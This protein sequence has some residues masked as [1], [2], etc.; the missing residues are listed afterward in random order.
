MRIHWQQL[1]FVLMTTACCSCSSGRD[2]GNASPTLDGPAALSTAD[3]KQTGAIEILPGG[4][5]ES[6]D[7]G[8]LSIDWTEQDGQPLATI[9]TTEAM[10]LRAAYLRI[11]IPGTATGS[12]SVSPGPWAGEDALSIA[13]PSADNTVDIGVCML[14]PDI[15]AG[16]SGSTTLATISFN[17]EAEVASTRT[18]S[19]PPVS[20][21][22]RIDL[23]YDPNRNFFYWYYRNQ[24]DYDQNG[25]VNVSDLTPIAVHFGKTSTGGFPVASVESVVDG[26]GN[27]EIN[28]ADISPIGVGFGSRVASFNIYQGTQGDYPASSTAASSIPELQSAALADALNTPAQGRLYYEVHSDAASDNTFAYW[29]RPVDSGTEGIPSEIAGLGNQAPS[30]SFTIEKNAGVDP[31]QLKADASASTDPEGGALEYFWFIVDGIFQAEFTDP[32]KVTLTQHVGPGN[33][34]VALYVRD[35]DGATGFASKQFSVAA[36]AGWQV[37]DLDIVAS[38]NPVVEIEDISLLGIDNR[39]YISTVYESTDRTVVTLN[40]GND[41]MWNQP[42]A[43]RR[44]NELMGGTQGQVDILDVGG[45]PGVVS[46][47]SGGGSYRV[48]YNYV[49][50]QQFTTPY[51]IALS[52]NNLRDIS[53]VMADGRPSVAIFDRDASEV[54]YALS[55]DAI[56]SHWDT[57]GMIDSGLNLGW[58]VSA[59]V[60]S[61]S[62]ALVYWDAQNKQVIYKDSHIDSGNVVWHVAFPVYNPTQIEIGDAV[63]DLPAG[64]QWLLLHDY[65]GNGLVNLRGNGFV[66]Q[67]Q[68]S[69]TAGDSHSEYSAKVVGDRVCYVFVDGGK[70]KFRRSTDGT[71]VSWFPVQ[72]ITDLTAED[73]WVSLA[74]V[75]G[76][77]AVAYVDDVTAM[78]HYA[79]LV[80]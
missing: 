8:S 63:L 21:G 56:G 51:N 38:G 19:A 45:V 42:L 74:D 4:I 58:N 13:V 16:F 44:I 26:D 49:E 46:L 5:F 7:P 61:G 20:A 32:G 64:G 59:G 39:P 11:A 9:S 25:E 6:L 54:L 17:G 36:N 18:A 3:Q 67:E 76:F 22:S 29:L 80:E 24:G 60:V 31:F 43:T 65:A 33:W 2:Q 47:Q 34:S 79:V 1:I 73:G 28:I 75:G 15:T 27:G 37:T 30:A 57:A 68:L 10:N 70:L 66:T 50:D 77:P 35:Q 78:A 71:G 48:E 69:A 12:A 40:Y 52:A 53:A 55:D 14:H 41:A 62:P 72:E 23:D